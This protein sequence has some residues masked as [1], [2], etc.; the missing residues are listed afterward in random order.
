V[1]ST[2]GGH[3]WIELGYAAHS[4][5]SDIQDIFMWQKHFRIAEQQLET[6]TGDTVEE[7]ALKALRFAQEAGDQKQIA[8]TLSLLGKFYVDINDQIAG[9]TLLQSVAAAEDAFGSSSLELADELELLSDVLEEAGELDLAEATKLR[10]L[11]I[12]ESSDSPQGFLNA[13]DMLV[14]FYIRYKM[15]DKAE[16]YFLPSHDIRK[17]LYG[18][19]SKQVYATTGRY[20]VIL[21][22]LGRAAEAADLE[23]AFDNYPKPGLDI[24]APDQYANEVAMLIEGIKSDANIDT[25]IGVYRYAM[26]KVAAIAQTNVASLAE[27]DP[28]RELKMQVQREPYRAIR[29]TLAQ[30]LRGKGNTEK[31]QDLLREAADHF[32]Q[33]V[34]E[35]D[36]AS[37]RSQLIFTVFDLCDFDRDHYI[38]LERLICESS[39][40]TSTLYTRALALYK[41]TGTTYEAREALQKAFNANPHVVRALIGPLDHDNEP[42]YFTIG[43]A[44]ALL[45]AREAANQ[46][47]STAGAMKFAADIV[48]PASI[49]HAFA[50]FAPA[51]VFV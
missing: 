24:P 38:E 3:N 40:C 11:E 51:P 5:R 48:M 30:L 32:R 35:A 20:S 7:H 47:I 1:K 14:G 28:F 37:D 39:E 17:R 27:S 34:A 22:G 13:V 43:E 12:R 21:K 44:E 4:H 15:F 41:R 18:G 6:G 2:S 36:N 8:I 45:Y 49:G 9:E 42:D 31:R 25:V 29:S 19:C 46:W 23:R 10:I 50:S 16:I 33:L 26:S